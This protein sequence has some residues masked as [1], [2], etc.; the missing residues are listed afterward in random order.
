MGGA[1]RGLLGL[2]LLAALA[3]GAFLYASSLPAC[4]CGMTPA[5]TIALVATGEPRAYEV[6]SASPALTYGAMDALVDDSLVSMTWADA[7]AYGEW[8]ARRDGA[9]LMRSDAVLVGDVVTF[10]GPGT[11]LKILDRA[12]NSYMLH[13]AMRDGS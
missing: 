7:L 4:G 6:A 10:A 9:P 1:S 12:A 5:Q 3:A 11:S 13:I 8:N 2:F